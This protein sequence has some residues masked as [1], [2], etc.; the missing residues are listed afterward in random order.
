MRISAQ[1]FECFFQK[2]PQAA[3]AQHQ[4]LHQALR[5]PPKTA[6]DVNF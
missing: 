4:T 2:A 3:Q 6:I 5:T 1:Q